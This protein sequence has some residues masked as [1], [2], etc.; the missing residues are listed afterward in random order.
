MMAELRVNKSEEMSVM[1][2]AKRA[3]VVCR[4]YPKMECDLKQRTASL[5][6]QP[7]LLLLNRCASCCEDPEK[8]RACEFAKKDALNVW[9]GG[10][11]RCR[12]KKERRA[13]QNEMADTAIIRIN[14]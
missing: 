11:L 14:F 13:R 5:N 3:W 1:N 9:W 7:S 10:L 6:M 2:A 4:Q 8:V 12:R